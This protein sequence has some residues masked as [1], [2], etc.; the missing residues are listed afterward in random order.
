MLQNPGLGPV[1]SSIRRALAGA[2]LEIG[3]YKGSF[4]QH[5]SVLLERLGIATVWDV[6]AHVG[7][8]GSSLRRHGFLR[9]IVSLEPSDAGFVILARV[10][11][12]DPLWFC[13]QV[14]AGRTRGRRALNLSRNGQSSSMLPIEPTHVDSE[15][16]S[17][18]IGS[19][20]VDVVLLDDL[21]S[22]LAPPPPHAIKLDVQGFELDAL[23]GAEQLLENCDLVEVELSLQKLYQ[24]GADWREVVDHLTQRNFVLVNLERVHHDRRTGDLLQINGLFRRPAAGN[25]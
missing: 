25:V 20:V 19:E 21:A 1:K 8:Y 10:A 13:E 2:G 14:A 18:Y 23:R 16:S 3:S 22:T 9:R 7:E 15:P 17:A 4:P 6:G 5:R 12:S 11:A 24:G